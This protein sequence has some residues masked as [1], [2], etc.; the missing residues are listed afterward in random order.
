MLTQMM[1]TLID[2][3]RQVLPPEAIGPLSQSLGNCAQPLTHRAGINLP[4]TRRLNQNGTVGPGAWNPSQYQNLFPGGDTYNAANYHTHVDVGG[5][6]VNW[7]EGNRY[8]SQFY[9]P[10][11]QTFQ[12]NQYFGGPTF[13]NVGGA[14]IDYITN[15]YFDGDTVNVENVTTQVFNG[16]PVQGPAGAPGA[17][18]RDGQRGAPGAP[19]GFF[20]VIPQGFF[21]NIDYL[22]GRPR[23]NFEPELVARP[24][25]YVK[26]AWVRPAITV[27]VPTNSISGGTVTV[28]CKST[29]FD[30]PTNAISGG[31]VTLSPTPNQVVIPTGITFNPETCAVSF[32]STTTVWAFPYEPSYLTISG[33]SATTQPITVAAITAVTATVS[34]EAA[35]TISV[36][37]ATTATSTLASKKADVA[38]FLVKNLDVDFWDDTEKVRVARNPTLAGINQAKVQVYTPNPGQ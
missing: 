36:L 35:S 38:G 31:T 30:L 20:G 7:N 9:F 4:G 27:A 17:D 32:S 19:G 22:T 18:G 25:R 12:Q 15:Q 13:H 23:L 26:D 5:M 21:K 28:F 16:E 3:L 24:H 6:N 8:D 33:E 34:G 29:S 10:L 11:T 37:A 14:D 2:A 1:P